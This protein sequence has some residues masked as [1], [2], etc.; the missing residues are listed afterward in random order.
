ME[1]L[2]EFRCIHCCGKFDYVDV[3]GI[4]GDDW[5]EG[6][7]SLS[8]KECQD[9]WCDWHGCGAKIIQEDTNVDDEYWKQELKVA[10]MDKEDLE[11]SDYQ[12]MICKECDKE[13]KK[14]PPTWRGNFD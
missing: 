5:R 2:S 9:S 13:R 12:W 6:D 8:E 7:C 4:Q 14:Q 1:T 10:E 11:V 3:W